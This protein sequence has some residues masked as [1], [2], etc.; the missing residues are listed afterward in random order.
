MFTVGLPLNVAVYLY[1]KICGN[2]WSRRCGHHLSARP[3]KPPCNTAMQAV[4]C[5]LSIMFGSYPAGF[6][7][8]T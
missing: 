8:L 7:G 6:Y 1:Y 3:Y 2:D 4:N 5:F